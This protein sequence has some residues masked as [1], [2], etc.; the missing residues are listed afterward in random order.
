MLSESA[1]RE[2]V[3]AKI[4]QDEQL[5]QQVGGSGH[6]GFVS[7]E[8]KR[9]SKPKKIKT[10]EFEGWEITY[11]YTTIVE[12]EFTMYPDNPPD[13]Y[14]YRKRIILNDNGIIIREFERKSTK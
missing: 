7:Y 14:K 4:A 11:D 1:L 5:G 2:I 10:D 12:T 3:K 6:L 13:K 8:I 9:I